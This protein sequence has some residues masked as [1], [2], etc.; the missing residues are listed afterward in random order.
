MNKK[1]F[2]FL[3]LLM[4]SVLAAIAQ[5][6]LKE[7]RSTVV[8]TIDGREF[9]IHTV[10]RGQTLFMISKAYGV[11]VDQIIRENPE[12]KEGIRS[13]QKLKIPIGP[14]KESGKESAKEPVKEPAKEPA[15]K[16]QKQVEV[17][18][19]ETPPVP[20][21]ELMPCEP[22]PKEGNAVY[23]VALM[24][25]LYL[26]EV[27]DI[28]VEDIVKRGNTD[29]HPFQFI[30]FYEGFCIALDSLKKSHILIKVTVFDVAKDTVKLKKILKDPELKKSDLIIGLLYNKP[31]RMVADFAQKNGIPLVNPLS[32]REQIVQG[33]P[34]VIKV[35]PTPSSQIPQV[36]RFIADEYKD[37]RILILHDGIPMK[38]GS[39]NFFKSCEEKNLDVH[40]TQ[41]YEAALEFF[42]K[43][44]E[45]V[46]VTFSGNKT[47]IL[48]LLSKLNEWRNDYQM[49]L[50]GLP[51]WDKIED[52]EVD[53]LVN[54]KSHIVAPDFIDYND[55]VTKKFVS[56]F[57]ERYKTDPDPLAFQGFDAGWYFLNALTFYGKTFEHCLPGFRMKLL[58]SDFRFVSSKGNGFENQNWEIYYYENFILRRATGK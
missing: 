48:D 40:T 23:N 18:P 19:V 41:S 50:F 45:N 27:N 5:D 13:E 55:T 52:I 37:A 20:S 4:T 10:K 47:Y 43:E 8:K 33:Y 17:M 35:Q 49:T 30:E 26:N 44:K 24:M 3:V 38:E 7:M 39:D 54:L 31:F 57:Q 25:P 46:I 16:Q 9:Y 42:S 28:N 12:V 51:R 32:E 29:I 11:D 56:L 6:R 53:Y 2:L 15:K 1:T 14:G 34:R 36:V 21:E 22:A 58:D